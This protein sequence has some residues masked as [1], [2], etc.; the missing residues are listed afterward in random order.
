MQKLLR[1]SGLVHRQAVRKNAARR[2]V[3]HSD[4]RKLREQEERQ[5]SALVRKDILAERKARREDWEQGPLAPKRDV[6]DPGKVYGALEPRRIR[7]VDKAKFKKYGIVVGDRVVIVK[8][9]HRD[10]GKIGKVTEVRVKAEE[11]SIE[12]LNMV[13]EHALEGM[14]LWS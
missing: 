13:R 8:E 10:Q 4:N 2:K 7:G 9:G 14:M 3:Q 5:V 6:G 12:G 1:R 11:C